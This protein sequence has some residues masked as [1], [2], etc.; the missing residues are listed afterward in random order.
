MLDAQAIR[1]HCARM[2]YLPMSPATLGPW[3]EWVLTVR[4]IGDASE[5]PLRMR[6]FARQEP[7]DP[8]SLEVAAEYP[9][10][11][12]TQKVHLLPGNVIVT[13]RGF[14]RMFEEA[15]AL[16][17]LALARFCL[18]C[19]REL[20]GQGR[21][22]GNFRLSNLSLE[23]LGLLDFGFAAACGRA[24]PDRESLRETLCL[25]GFEELLSQPNWELQL[26]RALKLR[27]E[28]QTEV[29]TI[30]P[31]E[32]EEAGS[33]CDFDGGEITG[34]AFSPD[35]RKLAATGY[36]PFIQLV[37]LSE[38]RAISL[39]NS[40]NILYEPGFS[41]D[42]SWLVARDYRS[43]LLWN[44]DTLECREIPWPSPIQRVD[45]DSSGG[46]VWVDQDGAVVVDPTTLA[47]RIEP[48]PVTLS[49]PRSGSHPTLPVRA[50]GERA[51][52]TNHGG[53][54]AGVQLLDR[55][56]NLLWSSP[57]CPDHVPDVVFSP[58]GNWLAAGSS[59]DDYSK[60]FPV[61]LWRM[62]VTK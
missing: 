13:V 52:M 18:R 12:V 26:C 28:P 55:Q 46:L 39:A 42:G 20:E 10:N 25:L 8:K 54:Q 44:L 51:G 59:G 43:V 58:D 47:A 5:T 30:P 16:D 34:L 60:N 4:R 31:F 6:L 19:L 33:L 36:H 29:A 1:S 56:G 14:C 7:V 27:P 40:G 9:G 11:L 49:S 37:D 45:F 38:R 22:H 50:V 35:S 32:L 23:P 2:R 53:L 15:E 57:V 61:Y 3:G 62:R 41:P 17:R 48:E 21:A 24:C